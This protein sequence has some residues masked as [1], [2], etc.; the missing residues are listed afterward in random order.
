MNGPS[1]SSL[2]HF[3]SELSF[4]KDLLLRGFRYSYS[5]EIFPQA[6]IRNE[7]TKY[8]KTFYYSSSRQNDAVAIPMICFCDIP[9]LRI[10][11]HCSKYG[12]YAIG[13]DKEMAR[14]IYGSMLNP[15]HYLS[16]SNDYI[17]LSDISVIKELDIPGCHNLHTSVNNLIALSKPYAGTI[18]DDGKCCF[19]DEREWRIYLPD[20][21]DTPYSWKWNIHFDKRND[22]KLWRNPLNDDLDASEF[23]RLSLV[24]GKELSKIDEENLINFFTHFIVRSEKEVEEIVNLLL[25]EKNTIFGYT[26]ISPMSRHLLV[27]KVSSMA[28]IKI[29]F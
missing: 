20:E 11:Q 27:S 8:Q 28:R 6:I 22:F 5:Y 4:L 1:S 24:K 9:L 3:T 18:M 23:G 21:S 16:S 26:N 15:I 13:I 19:Y 12:N 10:T 14:T 29:D 2:F 17:S 25:D 7:I